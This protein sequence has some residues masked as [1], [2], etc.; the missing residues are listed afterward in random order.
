MSSDVC[1]LLH[2]LQPLGQAQEALAHLL[3]PAQ[4]DVQLA[5]RLPQ[6]ALVGPPLV[7]SRVQRSVLDL[8]DAPRDD[9]LS[10]G[11]HGG[12]QRLTIGAVLLQELPGRQEDNGVKFKAGLGEL[13]NCWA[14]V[15]SLM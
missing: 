4:C 13:F 15:G 2:L 14:T 7:L 11:Q 6:A 9:F 10:A 12:K 3:Q 1:Q 8:R 5:L